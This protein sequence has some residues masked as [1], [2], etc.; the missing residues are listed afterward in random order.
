MM[1]ARNIPAKFRQVPMHRKAYLKDPY[2][3]APPKPFT[4][5]DYVLCVIAF[6][7]TGIACVPELTRLII[8]AGK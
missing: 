7:L 1:E 5:W 3:D 2:F 6:F 8:F 4:G